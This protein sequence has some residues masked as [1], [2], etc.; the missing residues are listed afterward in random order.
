MRVVLRGSLAAEERDLSGFVGHGWTVPLKQGR[1]CPLMTKA[2]RVLALLE[3][4]QDRAVRDRAGARGAARRRRPDAAPR[5]RVA[6]R[7][8]HPG[9]GRARPRR[10]L[11]AAARLPR[12]AAD[13]HGRRGR[14]GRARADGRAAAR[15]GDRRRAGEGPP[16]AARPRP[17]AGRV[18][19]AHARV[20]G[21]GR[22][23]AA[24]RRDAARAGRRGPPRAPGLSSLRGFGR[25]RVVARAEPVRRRRALGALVRAGVRPLARRSCARCARTGWRRCASAG[26]ASRS[27]PGSTRSRS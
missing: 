24:R 14:G 22:R 5:R 18:A 26:E 8:R 6:A 2:E 3:A 10:Q 27:I 16:R 23:R 11:P 20:H 1:I 25:R 12:P 17:A 21:L 15:A 13:V 9:R 19:R 4:L 7:A